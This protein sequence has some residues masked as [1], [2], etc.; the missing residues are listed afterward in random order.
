MFE[1]VIAELY[2]PGFDKRGKLA[3]NR[4]PSRVHAIGEE[5]QSDS[6]RDNE[7]DVGIQ[8]LS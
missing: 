7:V 2:L 1:G 6:G 5:R 3:A 8:Y 4:F